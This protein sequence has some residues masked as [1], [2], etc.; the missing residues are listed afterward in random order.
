MNRKCEPKRFFYTVIRSAKDDGIQAMMHCDALFDGLLT[1]GWNVP[2]DDPSLA[3]GAC[4]DVL[5]QRWDD[6]SSDALGHMRQA[7]DMLG[8]HAP[9]VDHVVV[10]VLSMREGTA[11]SVSVK[12]MEW[13]HPA[14]RSDR[15]VP[16]PVTSTQ[17]W[18]PTKVQS[19]G[20]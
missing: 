6:D 16:F 1:G 8:E 3:P 18:T 20:A 12:T 14:S 4:A 19:E 10:E 5:A 11:K 15:V 13:H 7:F 9:P 17:K 2:A